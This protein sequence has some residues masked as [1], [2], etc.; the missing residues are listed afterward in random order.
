MKQACGAGPCRQPRGL[1][2]WATLRHARAARHAISTGCH[3]R[4]YDLNAI[5]AKLGRAIDQSRLAKAEDL[6][7]RDEAAVSLCGGG[8]EHEVPPNTHERRQVLG[9]NQRR[10]KGSGCA[11]ISRLSADGW[12]RVFRAHCMHLDPRLEVQVERAGF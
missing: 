4:P 5:G 6:I 9:N 11:D 7:R 2:K 1:A 8:P 3:P 10:G 12:Y